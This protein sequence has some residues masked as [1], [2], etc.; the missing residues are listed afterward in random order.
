MRPF[1]QNFI[2]STDTFLKSLKASLTTSNFDALVSLLASDLTSQFEKAVLSCQFNRLGGLQFDRELRLIIAYLTTVTTWT[3]RDKFARLSQIS[4]IL[5]LENV[6]EI[7]DTWGS[8]S[9]S[10][11][12]RLTPTEVRQVLALRLVNYY[13]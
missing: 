7:L 13:F 11:T 3:I 9:G 4:A 8:N 12:W 5:N 1:I 2:I 10:L 6:N